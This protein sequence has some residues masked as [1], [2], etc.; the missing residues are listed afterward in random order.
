MSFFE[1]ILFEI[2]KGKKVRRKSW[3]NNEFIQLK[4]G[5]ILNQNNEKYFI[6]NNVLADDWEIFKEPLYDY[7]YIKSHGIPCWFW[8]CDYDSDI[9]YFYNR[10]L[11]RLII[12]DKDDY[13]WFGRECSKGYE[14]FR[15]CEPVKNH[16]LKFYEK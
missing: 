4:Y 3:E 1:E 9:D 7:E 15:Y 16:E 14:S 8:N 12:Y 6:D 2:R 5:N 11:G 10:C 13:L